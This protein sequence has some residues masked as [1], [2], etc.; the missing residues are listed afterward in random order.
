MNDSA[1]FGRFG[2]GLEIVNRPMMSVPDITH[3][4]IQKDRQMKPSVLS[5]G[6]YDLTTGITPPLYEV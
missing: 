2:S 3:D 4:R 6:P 5:N 1:W